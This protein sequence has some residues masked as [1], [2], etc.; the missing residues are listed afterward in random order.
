V[1]LKL[2][3]KRIN[4]RFY[5]VN[6]PRRHPVSLAADVEKPESVHE[7]SPRHDIR[8]EGN[9]TTPSSAPVVL[10]FGHVN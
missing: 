7:S 3:E 6:S 9:L 5:L 2:A 1:G 10:D 4:E 8:K